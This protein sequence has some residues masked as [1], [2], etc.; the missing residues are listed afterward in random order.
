MCSV[1]FK[2]Y[3]VEKPSYN[4]DMKTTVFSMKIKMKQNL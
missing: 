1:K 3:S 4:Y 2:K